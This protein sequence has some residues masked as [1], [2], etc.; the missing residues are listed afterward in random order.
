MHRASICMRN[1]LVRPGGPGAVA[2]MLATRAAAAVAVLFCLLSPLIGAHAEER[3]R[4]ITSGD[5]PPFVYTDPSGVLAGFEI[6]FANAVC[7]V[8][9]MRCEFTDLPFEEAIPAL[10]A[11]RGDAIVASMSITEER[12]KLIAFSDRYYRTPI[13]FVAAA[14]FNRPVTPDGLAGLKIGVIRGSTSEAYLRAHLTEP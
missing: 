7:A 5:Y 6:D 8:L 14:G 2:A 4:I 12:K 1:P 10:V 9:A 3:L 13:Q 11:R